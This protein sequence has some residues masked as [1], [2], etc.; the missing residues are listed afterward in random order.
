MATSIWDPAIQPRT[1]ADQAL[2]VQAR[3]RGIAIPRPFPSP[4][5]W[6]DLLIYQVLIDR[7][8]NPDSGPRAAWD[9]PYDGFQGGTFD[10]LRQQLDYLQDLGIGALWLSPVQK[11]CLYSST[12]YHGYGIQDFVAIDPRFASDPQAARQDPQLAE[13]ELQAL[14]DAAHERGIYVIFDIVLNHTGDVFGYSG[15]GSVAPWNNEPYTIHW[16]DAAGQEQQDWTS[17]PTNPPLDAVVWPEELQEN[18]YYLRHGNAFTRPPSEQEAGG[19]FFSLKQFDTH[20]HGWNP[21]HGDYYPVRDTLIHAYQ[22]LIAKFDV[23]GYRID[24][25]KYIG[26]D[27]AQIFG[28]AIREFALS[29]G[30]KNFFTF[31]EVY[32]DEEK[33]ARFIGRNTLENGDLTGVD[34]ALDFPLFYKLPGMA[35]GQVP[36]AD[37]AAVFQ[38]RKTVERFILS[39]HGEAGR[40]FVTFLDNHDQHSRLYYSDPAQPHRYDDQ[41]TIGLSCLFALQGVPCIYYGT[42]QGLHGSADAPEAVREALWGMPNAFDRGH[43]FYQAIRQLTTLRAN[44]PALRYGRQYFRPIS[45]DGTHFGISSFP[46]GLLAFSRLLQDLEVLVVANTATE[47]PWTG[48]VIVD[49]ALNPVGTT[50]QVLYT[51]KAKAEVVPPQP[52]AEKPAGAVEIHE[53]DGAVTHGPA[54]MLHVSLQ[55]MEIQILGIPR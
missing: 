31:G 29:I 45:G 1:V 3:T 20:I 26:S 17:P 39:S 19:D 37:V 8:N 42:E 33:I 55:P 22:Y 46:S 13:A 18:D 47:Q 40:Y 44:Q 32:D 49:F 12:T 41:V 16:R 30:K 52:V 2:E 36:P 24:T 28:N 34:A 21:V 43:P 35:K 14:I 54:R 23:D 38:K 48:D 27:F 7:F 4:Q 15:Y 53:V 9:R 5:D 11:N 10:G 6:R 51:N 50:Y 25:L